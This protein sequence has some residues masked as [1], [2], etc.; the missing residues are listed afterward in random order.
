MKNKHVGAENRKCLKHEL[1]QSVKLYLHG[2]TTT[3]TREH[4]QLAVSVAAAR[5]RQTNMVR[6]DLGRGSVRMCP[7]SF[8]AT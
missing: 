3:E 2:L 4:L 6:V 1:G 7:D 8:T 5:L